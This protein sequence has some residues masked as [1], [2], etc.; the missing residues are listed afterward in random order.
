MN[1]LSLQLLRVLVLTG[2][3]AL[4]IYLLQAIESTNRFIH[5]GIWAI[6]IFS[7]LVAVIIGIINHV[8]IK[9]I[10]KLGLPNLF[11]ATTV[12]RLILSMAFLG[13]M[14]FGDIERKVVWVADFFAV[15]L[16]YLV[17]EI[18][19]IMS[20]LRA[21]STKGEKKMTKKPSTIASKILIISFI[22]AVF[23]IINLPNAFAAS[24]GGEAKEEG[25]WS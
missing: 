9:K 14:I 11:L 22:A 12:I 8:G 7:A 16:F 2:L 25:G 3:I 17:F 13:I 10:D 1:A 23:S 15:Y 20:N 18:Y 4:S 5:P 24:G 6:L 19:S 21:I